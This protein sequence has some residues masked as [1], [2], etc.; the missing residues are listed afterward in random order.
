LLIFSLK[1]AIEQL[2]S[3]KS[4]NRVGYIISHSLVELG[5]SMAD[6]IV[7]F[8]CRRFLSGLGTPVKYDETLGWILANTG[9]AV[10]EAGCRNEGDGRFFQRRRNTLAI[11]T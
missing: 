8:S 9:L 1:F 7:L 2:R 5:S 4:Q 10:A 6:P 11:K 3:G